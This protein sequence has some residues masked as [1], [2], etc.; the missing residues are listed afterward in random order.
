MLLAW[1]TLAVAY[2]A[3]TLGERLLRGQDISYGIYVFHAIAL[4]LMFEHG[5]RS[6]ASLGAL[7][8]SSVALAAI[9]WTLVE[10]P[11]LR[12]KQSGARGAAAAVAMGLPHAAV[13]TAQVEPA[14]AGS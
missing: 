3:S 11:A 1:T 2:S 8:A 5:W 4:N 13:Q 6:P 7:L 10:K 14:D 12:R 9:S